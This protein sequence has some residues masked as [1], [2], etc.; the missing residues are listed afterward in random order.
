MPVQCLAERALS[1]GARKQREKGFL[2]GAVSP[3]VSGTHAKPM[4]Q[5]RGSHEADGKQYLL[6]DNAQFSMENPGCNV[7]LCA[8]IAGVELLSNPL[9]PSGLPLASSI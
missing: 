6:L 5:G 4:L 9:H 2:T 3:N 8:F 7:F 1:D